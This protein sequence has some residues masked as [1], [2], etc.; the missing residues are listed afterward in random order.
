[1]A[2]SC[3]G[4][5]NID[6]ECKVDLTWQRSWIAPAYPVYAE[7]L[8][9]A[10]HEFYPSIFGITADVDSPLIIQNEISLG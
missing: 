4:A 3:R 5:V 6:T 1:M 9:D 8:S 10:E 7:Y 2:V